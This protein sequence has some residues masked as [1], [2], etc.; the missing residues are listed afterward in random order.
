MSD[1]FKDTAES[2]LVEEPRQSQTTYSAERPQGTRGFGSHTLW[3]PPP[4]VLLDTGAP[5]GG[6][7]EG[8]RQGRRRPI[9]PN[10]ERRRSLTS[11]KNALLRST[12]E[13]SRLSASAVSKSPSVRS[14]NRRPTTIASRSG[15]ESTVATLQK[16]NSKRGGFAEEPPP[17]RPWTRT[18]HNVPSTSTVASPSS[19]FSSG[20][21]ARGATGFA[22]S[23]TGVGLPGS[24]A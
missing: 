8:H 17:E 18:V 2:R 16:P 7:S 15:W 6:S 9:T 12:T 24:G 11:E 22:T 20:E 14:L 1:R 4:S 23:R 10:Q 19:G 13:G 21:A 3:S 5:A